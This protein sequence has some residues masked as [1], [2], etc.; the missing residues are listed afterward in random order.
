MNGIQGG[1]QPDENVIDPLIQWLKFL[2]IKK[3]N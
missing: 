1:N 2:N 3:E